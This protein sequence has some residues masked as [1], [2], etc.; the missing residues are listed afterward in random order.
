[1][2][3]SLPLATVD[4]LN[5]RLQQHVREVATLRL[6]VDMQRH[7]IAQ[8]LPDYVWPDHRQTLPEIRLHVASHRELA[9]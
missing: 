3:H 2:V 1:M 7:R 4:H 9:R 6:A 8:T 5:A